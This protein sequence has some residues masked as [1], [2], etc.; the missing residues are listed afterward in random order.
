M[1]GFNSTG[2][3]KALPVNMR[4]P[5]PNGETARGASFNFDFTGGT[6]NI[7]CSLNAIDY[8]ISF[9][10]TIFID[11][12]NNPQTASVNPTG[13][14][15]KL[16]CPAYSQGY[17]PILTVGP[18]LSFTAS[19][20]GNVVVPMVLL[21]IFIDMMLWSVQLPG[22]IAGSVNVNGTVIIQPY[23]GVY[24]PKNVAII[25]SNVG[26][27]CI[28]SNGARKRFYVNN[29]PT[30]VGQNIA[31]AESIFLNIT[32]GN[33]R[34]NDGIALELQPGQTFDTGSGPCTTAAISV[35]S[36]TAGHLV[37]AGELT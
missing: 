11:N 32:G 37:L 3:G 10:Q 15:Q 29:P 2:G 1:G 14:N 35:T 36:F 27:T 18:T 26:L 17:F 6:V 25:T 4:S 5:L 22:S 30:S 7:P 21:N 33:A 8:G 24:A 13:T 16:V 12:S 19:S 20:G 28:L 9:F 31:A 23:A 34:I